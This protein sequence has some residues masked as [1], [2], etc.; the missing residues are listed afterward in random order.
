MCKAMAVHQFLTSL[1]V[2]SAY[3]FCSFWQ[4]AEEQHQN[5][6]N[7]P[8]Q[9]A[10]VSRNSFAHAVAHGAPQQSQQSKATAVQRDADTTQDVSSAAPAGD[11]SPVEISW[12]VG[13]SPEADEDP[14][15]GEPSG[16]SWDVDSG[17]ASDVEPAEAAT[18]ISWDVEVETPSVANAGDGAAGISWDICMDPATMGMTEEA[19]SGTDVQVDIDWDVEVA[20]QGAAAADA[21]KGVSIDWDVGDGGGADGAEPDAPE[22]AGIDSSQTTHANDVTGALIAD[23]NFRTR[24]PMRASSQEP[25]L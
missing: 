20:E 11:D 24:S 9:K 14:T 1:C 23:N 19:V 18:G 12:D 8:S 3:G 6:K 25:R 4:R 15:A 22:A 16:I 21:I 10:L 7:T 2:R 17:P 5:S 13:A